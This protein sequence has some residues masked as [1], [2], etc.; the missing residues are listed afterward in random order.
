MYLQEYVNALYMKTEEKNY[1]TFSSTHL[2]C[3]EL[4]EPDRML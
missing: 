1:L 4:V 2:N 3:V